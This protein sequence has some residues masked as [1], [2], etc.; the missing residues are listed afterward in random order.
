MDIANIYRLLWL[1][2][3]LLLLY[4]DSDRV[5]FTCSCNIIYFVFSYTWFVPQKLKIS[6]FSSALNGYAKIKY[7]SQELF[8]VLSLL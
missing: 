5:T 6:F 2:R 1:C 8:V 7:M 3:V 4:V